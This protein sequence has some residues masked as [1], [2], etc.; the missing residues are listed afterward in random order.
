MLLPWL[1]CVFILRAHDSCHPHTSSL[2]HSQPSFSTC[3]LRE[4]AEKSPMFF[5]DGCQHIK[6]QFVTFF[7][8]K[9]SLL[10][11]FLVAPSYVRGLDCQ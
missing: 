7:S 5:L 1:L 8:L 2:Q 11:V 4:L 9:S 3:S 10:N 6:L